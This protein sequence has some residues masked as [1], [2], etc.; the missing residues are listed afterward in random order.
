MKAKSALEGILVA[1]FSWLIT[2]PL[3]ARTLA[4]YGAQVIK[5]E[6]PERPDDMRA[7]PPYKDNKPGINRSWAINNFNS[8]KLGMTLDLNNPQGLELAKEVIK[9]SDVMIENFRPG[10][11][12]RWEL[13]YRDIKAT[14]PAIVMLS[15]TGQGQGG[16]LAKARFTGLQLQAYGGLTHFLGWP[17]R[18]PAAIPVP[19]S[20]FVLPWFAISAVVTALAHC[21]KT[22][23]GKYIDISMLETLVHFAAPI[24]LDYTVN[25]RLQGR[26]GNRSDHMVP[27]GVF[28]C[29]GDDRW[30]AIAVETHNEWIALCK[31]MG[32]PEL[33]MDPRFSTI[34][35]RKRNEDELEK[36]IGV[37]TKDKDASVVMEEL[38]KAGVPAGVVQNAQDLFENDPQMK[39]R[40]YLQKLNQSEIGEYTCQGV[41]FRLS[42][43]QGR[44]QRG[45]PC[46]GE[47]N[48]YV[49]TKILGFSDE[50]F[51]E[52]YKNGAFGRI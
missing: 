18:G 41:P 5:I 3:T 9:R 35:M 24:L 32:R 42:K 21:R 26:K 22:G 38:Q 29:K 45:A 15:L 25:A 11:L 37:W 10:T 19:Y 20:D 30:C 34:L 40:C 50:R 36:I 31:T 4:E 33:I 1:D 43:T 48:H 27:H 13:E 14:N 51:V 2:G 7:I 52:Y 8:G 44:Y 39:H 12:K 49:C 28:C 6:A 23:K 17:D 47:H 16:P 46:F